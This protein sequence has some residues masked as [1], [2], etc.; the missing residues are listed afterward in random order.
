MQLLTGK[1]HGLDLPIVANAELIERH[2]LPAAFQPGP[3]FE[4]E[5]DVPTPCGSGE[6]GLAAAHAGK[7]TVAILAENSSF[8]PGH[9]TH[10]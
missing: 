4:G 1:L 7:F 5:R 9:R 10:V 2:E 8:E 6:D 3:R